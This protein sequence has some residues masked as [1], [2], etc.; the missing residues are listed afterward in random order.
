MTA[1]DWKPNPI[2]PQE[3]LKLLG[4]IYAKTAVRPAPF[5]MVQFILSTAG[6][7][8]IPKA[9]AVCKAM[10]LQGY[11]RN[12]GNNRYPLWYWYELAG[13]PTLSMAREVI[14]AVNRY[15]NA[16]SERNRIKRALGENYDEENNQALRQ[17]GMAGEVAA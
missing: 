14:C 11:V 4:A 15:N 8:I 17:Q 7:S 3:M 2:V 13:P 12:V 1:E 10:Q 6:K 16:A 5:S 9:R